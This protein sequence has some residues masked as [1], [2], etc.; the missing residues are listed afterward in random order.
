MSLHF[1]RVIEYVGWNGGLTS[2]ANLHSFKT[3]SIESKDIR[4][5]VD[6]YLSVGEWV[7]DQSVAFMGSSHYFERKR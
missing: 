2:S 3:N 6:K 4:G 1:S 7:M 5:A